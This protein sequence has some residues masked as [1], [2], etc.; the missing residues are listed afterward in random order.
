VT[1]ADGADVLPVFSPDGKWLL[2]TGQRHEGRSS[3]LYI[4]VYRDQPAAA[5]DSG[6]PGA[7]DAAP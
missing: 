3:Q 7:G 1:E 2:W 4:G 5:K 6:D